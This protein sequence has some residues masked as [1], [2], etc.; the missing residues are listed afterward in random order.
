MR[1]SQKLKVRGHVRLVDRWPQTVWWRPSWSPHLVRLL[2]KPGQDP[3]HLGGAQLAVLGRE[4][5]DRGRDD[6]HS[7]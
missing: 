7:G 3:A 5:V 6:P 1:R 2:A 4:G